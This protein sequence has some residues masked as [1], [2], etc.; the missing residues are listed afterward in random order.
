M[1]ERHYTMTAEILDQTSEIETIQKELIFYQKRKCKA[2]I[3]N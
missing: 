2:Q 1:K 3:P